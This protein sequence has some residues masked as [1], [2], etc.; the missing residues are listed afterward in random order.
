MGK[1]WPR[2]LWGPGIFT[3]MNLKKL[4]QWP[5]SR[6]IAAMFRVFSESFSRA[7]SSASMT[8]IWLQ[9]CSGQFQL[10]LKQ[11][12]FFPCMRWFIWGKPSINTTKT[13]HDLPVRQFAQHCLLYLHSCCLSACKLECDRHNSYGCKVMRVEF[14]P[15]HQY[16]LFLNETFHPHPK[17][18]VQQ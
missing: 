11:H 5:S 18:K 16:I 13:H 1:L 6:R 9:L 4:H 8:L 3:A 17:L 10:T 2:D 14:Q 7:N 12:G 15:C